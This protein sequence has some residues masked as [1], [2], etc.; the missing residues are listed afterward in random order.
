MHNVLLVQVCE[1][2]RFVQTKIVQTIAQKHK[3]ATGATRTKGGNGERKIQDV[4][5]GPFDRE[6]EKGSST[7][8]RE[9]EKVRQIRS[10]SVGDGTATVTGA[11]A[12]VQL[13][14]C[15]ISACKKNAQ[16]ERVRSAHIK[17]TSFTR[18]TIE[19]AVATTDKPKQKL[20]LDLNND[21]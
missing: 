1:K 18:T 16:D 9:A 11:G 13:Q 10:R 8:R 7:R 5:Y 20:K 19:S 2:K 14:R 3:I 12:D 21:K 4:D 17:S 6:M 15:T